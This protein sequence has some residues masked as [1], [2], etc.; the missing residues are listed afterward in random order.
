MFK[1]YNFISNKV[2]LNLIIHKNIQTPKYSTLFENTIIVKKNS[3]L[4]FERTRLFP[5]CRSSVQVRRTLVAK[6]ARSQHLEGLA[7]VLPNKQL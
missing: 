4:S 2:L 6:L 3:F 1:Y 7:K 5:A